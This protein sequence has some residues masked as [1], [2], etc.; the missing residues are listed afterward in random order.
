MPVATVTYRHVELDRHDLLLAE[1]L[2]AERYLNFNNRPFFEDGASHALTNP[3]FVPSGL[4]ERCLP[5]AV[6]GPIVE[7]ERR[8]LD[9]VFAT[10][11]AAACGWPTSDHVA[12]W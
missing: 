1:G 3:D 2:P 7:A 4:S 11:L 8:R 5:A 12:I 9:A 10:G 6:K